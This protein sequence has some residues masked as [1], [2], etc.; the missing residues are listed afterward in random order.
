MKIPGQL[1]VQINTHARNREAPFDVAIVEREDVTEIDLVEIEG[2]KAAN[3][4]YVEATPIKPSHH[5]C[6]LHAAP[7][8]VLTSMSE[9]VVAVEGPVHIDEVVNRVREAWGLKRAG[10]RIQ[11]AIEAAIAIAV[12]MKRLSQDDD[13]F[14]SVPGASVIIRDRTNVKSLSLR[15][16]EMLPPS[17]I[18]AAIIEIV[19]TN[20][21][22]THDQILQAVSRALGFKST[23]GLLR[24]AI[25][26]VVDE[27]LSQKELIDQQ[28]LLML[29]P[30]AQI[31]LPV[32]LDAGGIRQLIAEGEHERLEFKQT[33]FWDVTLNQ[34]NKKIE[35]V[36]VKTIAAFA[37]KTGG[38]LLVGVR[39][40]G[41]AVGI[42]PDIKYVGGNLDKLELRFSSLI[43]SHFTKSFRA[44]RVIVSFPVVGENQICKIDV[45]PASEA[46]FITIADGQGRSAERFFVRSGNSSQEL[47]P[48]E[49]HRFVK[50]RFS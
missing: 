31:E 42:G 11:E 20:Y 29:G 15:R 9:Q 21:G 35:E 49:T 48:S 27:A 18:R 43:H 14:L 5:N 12:R 32:Q 17:E 19:R 46:I 25:R 13:F 4:L 24:G 45:R 22:A 30:A 2:P 8:G 50:E 26:P 28:G 23:K 39:D 36:I 44:S 10:G 41:V 7:T 16:P 6:E 34:Y 38:T 37:N 47:P 1:S 3:S 40:D 33:L